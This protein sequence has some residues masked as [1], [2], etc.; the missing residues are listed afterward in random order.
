MSDTKQ[1]PESDKPFYLAVGS[2]IGL[3]ILYI[4]PLF[5]EAP[6]TYNDGLTLMGI[7]TTMAWAFYFKAKT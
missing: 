4:L 5:F 6:D 1:I 7:L 3:L 2:L